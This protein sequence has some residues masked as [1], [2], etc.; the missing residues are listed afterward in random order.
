MSHV[1]IYYV[2]K[3][4]SEIMWH[5]RDLSVRRL[6]SLGRPLSKIK[7][8][9]FVGYNFWEIFFMSYVRQQTLVEALSLNETDCIIHMCTSYLVQIMSKPCAL[10][11]SSGSLDLRQRF[12]FKPIFLKYCAVWVRQRF[13]FPEAT[14][15]ARLI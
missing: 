12:N 10:A 6:Y 15:E 3:P 7:P 5:S 13:I 11:I 9:L 1:R 4:L 8:P 2:L 14:L